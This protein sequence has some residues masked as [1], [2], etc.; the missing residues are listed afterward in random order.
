V[1]THTS[2]LDIAPTLL[3]LAGVDI[4]DE[5][6]GHSL[7]P[8][9]DGVEDPERTVVGEYLG[10]GAVAPIFMLRRGPLKYLFSEPDGDQLY[11]L[12]A[13]PQERHNLAGDPGHGSDVAA[14][15][16]EVARR[17]DIAEVHRAVLASQA[18]RRVVDTALRQGRYTP[19]D[20]QPGTDAANQYMRN[21]LDLNDVETGRRSG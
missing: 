7:M 15:R 4:P 6:D 3:A 10:E 20:F 5:L 18:N 16:A 12:V 14:L 1:A 8:Q 11:D 13:D 17:W 2:L 9:L 21:H 19:W